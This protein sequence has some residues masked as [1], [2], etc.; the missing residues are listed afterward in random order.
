MLMLNS[1]IES[2]NRRLDAQERC[3]YK[4]VAICLVAFSVLMSFICYKCNW[5]N[6]AVNL[7]VGVI[8]T[9]G[10]LIPCLQV[11]N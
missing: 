9:G 7:A 8:L 10:L 1:P 6:T 3:I 4:K 5:E 11:T 2:E